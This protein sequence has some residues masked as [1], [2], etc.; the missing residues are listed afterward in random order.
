MFLIK[1]ATGQYAAGSFE[2]LEEARNWCN[3]QIGV[4]APYEIY[5]AGDLV[6]TVAE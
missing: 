2:T 3:C 1:L 6:E 5:C 4:A